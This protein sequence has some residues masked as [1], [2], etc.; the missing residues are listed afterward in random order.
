MA[1]DFVGTNNVNYLEP[2]GQ[3]GTRNLGGKD[4]ASAR[5]IFTT[6]SSITRKLFIEE[7]DHLLNYLTDD[8]ELVEPEWYMPILPTVL[9]N[10]AEGIGTGWSTFIPCFNPKEL[11]ST[12]KRRLRGE[13]FEE[14]E[15]DPWYRG[16]T[17]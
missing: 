6:L 7:D 8:G 17:G 4:A 2:I 9:I 16:F 14:M 3:F 10:G 5:Y 12:F 11:A 1:Q 15:I 13:Q